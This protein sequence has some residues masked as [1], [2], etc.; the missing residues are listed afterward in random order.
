MKK[1][2]LLGV[3]LGL[4]FACQNAEPAKEADTTS[5]AVAASEIIKKEVMDIH[6]KVM[7]EMTTMSKLQGKLQES[8][9]GSQDSMIYMTAAQDLKFAK[10]AMMEW[11]RSFSGTYND[12]MTEEEKVTFLK[13]EKAKM[14]RIDS[15][16]EAA[17]DNGQEIITAMPVAQDSL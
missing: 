6:D 8:S 15:L 11:M 5:E 9:V 2:T 4:S 14:L 16:S 17:I 13:A 12:N 10:Q 7:P 3:L 1:L